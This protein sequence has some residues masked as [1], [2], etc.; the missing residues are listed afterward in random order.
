MAMG[1]AVLE[2]VEE[3]AVV[4]MLLLLLTEAGEKADVDAAIKARRTAT[5][6][7]ACLDSRL[8]GRMVVNLD[9]SLGSSWARSR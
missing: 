2:A 8:A 3:E 6:T 4:L 5:K 1:R 7:V 9:Q